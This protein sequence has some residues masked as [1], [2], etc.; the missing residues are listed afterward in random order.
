MLHLSYFNCCANIN[1]IF[2]FKCPK[3]WKKSY[4]NCQ[5]LLDHPINMCEFLNC[6]NMNNYNNVCVDLGWNLKNFLFSKC[7]LH[8]LYILLRS[9]RFLVGIFLTTFFNLIRY[10]IFIASFP[11][12]T[13]ENDKPNFYHRYFIS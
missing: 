4:L 12:C 1:E 8:N 2:F 7:N 5:I 13:C 9:L 6:C 11:W 10:F 3:C